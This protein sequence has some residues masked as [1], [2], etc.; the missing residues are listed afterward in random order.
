MENKEINAIID[1][2]VLL[3]TKLENNESLRN[4]YQMVPQLPLACDFY[5]LLLP[6]DD[7]QWNKLVNQFIEEKP[8][9]NKYFTPE[10]SSKLAEY[11]NYCLN[12]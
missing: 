8:L 12:R 3:Q 9:I 5:G 11:T 2:G 10:T 7:P 6:K 4:N 1:D